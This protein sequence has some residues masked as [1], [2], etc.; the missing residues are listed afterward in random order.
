[1]FVPFPMFHMR[2]KLTQK[3]GNQACNHLSEA[4]LFVSQSCPGLSVCRYHLVQSEGTAQVSEN[5]SQ[6][7]TVRAQSIRQLCSM[8]VCFAYRNLIDVLAK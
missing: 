4:F 1:M 8:S 5:A 6:D 2:R 3:L 7:T